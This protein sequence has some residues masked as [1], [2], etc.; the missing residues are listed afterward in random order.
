MSIHLVGGGDR[1]DVDEA[2][3]GPFVAECAARV[4]ATEEGRL[5]RVALLTVTEGADP[6]HGER[7][8]AS[9]SRAGAV[10]VLHTVVEEGERM[11]A[12]VLD[13][14]D[15]IAVGGGLTPRY[16]EA[17]APLAE[18]I[19]AA[20]ETGTPYL[21]FSAGAMIAPDRALIGGWRIDGVE[22]GDEQ[23]SEELDELTIVDGLGLIDVTVEVHAA[24]WGNLTRA[25]AAVDSG[26][27]EEAVAVDEC[28]VL[29]VGTGPLR[30]AGAGTVWV[31][32]RDER[33]VLV[34]SMR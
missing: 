14:V 9:L 3:Y 17:M 4:P 13:G 1:A 2:V 21:G 15:G 12:A 19:R 25:I 32:T 6:A 30:V 29:I 27:V 11:P 8:T 31:L 16:L 28:T 34:R 26:A 33:G 22:I 5:P 18:G 20:V 24:Q 7:L 10:E 23:A